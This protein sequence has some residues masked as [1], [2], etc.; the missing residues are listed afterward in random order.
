MKKALRTI[1]ILVTAWILTGCGATANL[2]SNINNNQTNVTLSKNNYHIVKTV[3]SEVS[4]TY[5]FGLGGLSKKSLHDNAVAEL[6][7]KANLKGS[8]A[9]IN[10]TVKQSVKSLLIYT[11]VTYYAEGTVIQ[12][13]R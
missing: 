7:K 5:Y 1:L 6:T 2:T 8:Q 3:E 11:R 12:F 9:L 4:S 10:I 13:D